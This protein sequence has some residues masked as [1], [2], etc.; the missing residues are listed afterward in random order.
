MSALLSMTGVSRAFPLD[1]NPAT[2]NG[3]SNKSQNTTQSIANQKPNSEKGVSLVPIPG[4]HETPK[5]RKRIDELA[6]WLEPMCSDPSQV[7]QLARNATGD[8]GQTTWDYLDESIGVDQTNIRIRALQVGCKEC[9]CDR[10]AGLDSVGAI[11]LRPNPQS[12]FCTEAAWARHCTEELGCYCYVYLE[13]KEKDSDRI[14]APGSD[15]QLN[16]GFTKNP[17]AKPNARLRNLRDY[18][19]LGGVM[20]PPRKKNQGATFRRLAPGTKEPYYLEGP[21]QDSGAWLK[22]LQN[23]LSSPTKGL[24]RRSGSDTSENDLADSVGKNSNPRLRDNKE[25]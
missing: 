9:K 20:A 11:R 5:L 4:Y 7:R 12:A 14:G 24:K 16:Q 19:G 22:S 6:T 13:R 17:K 10:Q 23:G 1:A 25:H 21:D 15:W 3:I 2:E 18:V 8:T